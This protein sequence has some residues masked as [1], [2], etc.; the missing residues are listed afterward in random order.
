MPFLDDQLPKALLDAVNA[1]VNVDGGSAVD[2]G[3]GGDATSSGGQ[4][5]DIFES[6]ASHFVCHVVIEPHELLL[7]ELMFYGRSLLLDYGH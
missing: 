5:N 7:T 2:G 3:G 1:G 6:V 4:G